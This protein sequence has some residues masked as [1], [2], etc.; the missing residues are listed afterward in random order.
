MSHEM[1]K[2]LITIGAILT[3]MAMIAVLG[4]AISS[5]SADD[6]TRSA[7][8]RLNH[9]GYEA[10]VPDGIQGRDTTRAIRRFQREAG[11]RVTG[12]LNVRTLRKLFADEKQEEPELL[13]AIPSIERREQ[14]KCGDMIER[15]GE[16]K[17][18]Q[19]VARREAVKAWRT[20]AADAYG[21]DYVNPA[22]AQEYR[23]E[24]RPACAT[25][26]VSFECW[27]KGRPC[28]P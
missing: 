2:I 9:L 18:T 23:V 26:T 12:D 24:C 22:Q 27:V 15:L 4:W 13:A 5:A 19:F 25:C 6:A 28:R 16:K 3:L 14:P 1:K 21:L 7:Q 10:G 20:A 17:W 8:R 11:L